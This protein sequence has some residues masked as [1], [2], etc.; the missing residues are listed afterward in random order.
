LNTVQLLKAASTGLGCS[1]PL[2]VS[3]GWNPPGFPFAIHSVGS[4]LMGCQMMPGMSPVQCMKVAEHLYTS[5]YI[6]YTAQMTETAHSAESSGFLENWC[7][8]QL[9][10]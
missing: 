9:L 10:W 1:A 5:G 6:S 3:H 2:V 4:M 7:Q 8:L